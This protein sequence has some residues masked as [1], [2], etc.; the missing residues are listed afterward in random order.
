M[1]FFKPRRPLAIPSLLAALALS[2]ACGE[3]ESDTNSR[4]E[5]LT[6][7]NLIEDFATYAEAN[8]SYKVVE[9]CIIVAAPEP[10]GC[11]STLGGISGEPINMEAE[12]GAA[13]YID[14]F[15]SGECGDISRES[16]CDFGPYRNL[17]CVEGRCVVDEGLEGCLEQE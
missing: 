16:G 4:T 11:A 6:C 15:N 14:L 7:D 13:P 5:P 10:C 8:R 9:D 12:A 17:D 2:F 3:S 1:P